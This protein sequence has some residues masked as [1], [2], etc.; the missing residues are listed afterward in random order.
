MQFRNAESPVF[1]S[2]AADAR[3]FVRPRGGAHLTS[4]F[5]RLHKPHSCA[6]KLAHEWGTLKR[7]TECRARYL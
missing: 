5:G 4:S 7:I 1:S 6:V 3:R 2:Y